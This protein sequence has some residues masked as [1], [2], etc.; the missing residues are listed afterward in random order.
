MFILSLLN[1]WKMNKETTVTI[2]KQSDLWRF[3]IES[4]KYKLAGFGESQDEAEQ[5]AYFA[6]TGIP[7]YDTIHIVYKD[8][9][10]PKPIMVK[11]SK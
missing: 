10:K 1:A 4:G 5:K 3:E 6:L 2:F 8:G 9:K 11:E 7:N